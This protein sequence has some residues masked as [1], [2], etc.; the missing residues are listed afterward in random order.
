MN[1]DD[2]DQVCTCILD[3][4][5]SSTSPDPAHTTRPPCEH[6]P[7]LRFPYDRDFDDVTCQRAVSEVK[8]AGRVTLRSLTPSSPHYAHFPGNS[9]LEVPFLRGYFAG[10]HVTVFSVSLFFRVEASELN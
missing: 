4:S 2:S 6:D 9:Y 8:G 10:S 5:D 7:L 1:F 3:T